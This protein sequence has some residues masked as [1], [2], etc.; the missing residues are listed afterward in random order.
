[1]GKF[2]KIP[3]D[4]FNALQ[5]DAG[6]ILTNF[7]PSNPVEPA[8]Q[9]ILCATT[10]GVTIT[11]T[12][13]FSDLGED[14]DNVPS[15]MMELMHLDGWDCS[16]AT[17]SIGTSLEML[18]WAL[19]SADITA[20]QNK[21]KPRKDLSQTDFQTIWWVGDRADGGTVAVK[22]L[23]GLSTSG[24]SLTTSK[25]G[26][27]QTAI[28]ISGHMSIN[29]QN[30]MPMEFYSIDPDTFTVTF[31]S[32]GGSAVASQIVGN[33]EKATEPVDP[34]KFGYEFGGWY[35]EAQFINEWDFTTDT[36]TANIILYAKWTA[37]YVVT[38]NSNGGTAVAAE[39]VLA[40]GKATE[41]TPPTKQGFTFGGWYK[42]DT[43]T[44]A[45]DF[46]TDTVNQNT[47]LY[48]KWTED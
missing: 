5:L 22:L 21:V 15:N 25:N 19:G 6:V 24:M 48:A 23:N 31:N 33:G 29:A 41:P 43:L 34:T 8:D 2:T 46:S 32:N 44:T 7:D 42:N 36:V 3:Q 12:P 10:G 17:T 4:T 30:D 20:A 38:Y 27:G 13:T 39:T 18:R 35:K 9:D 37:E 16:I 47:T 26:K 28:T 45:W 1:M 14:I 11:C 40:G